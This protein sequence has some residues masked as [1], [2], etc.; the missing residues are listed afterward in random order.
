MAWGD[1]FKSA[2]NKASSGV[3]S[4]AG[5]IA[6]G[7]KKAAG[8]VKDKAVSA[9]NW[10]KNKTKETYNWAKNKAKQGYNWIKDKARKFGKMVKNAYLAV[11]KKFGELKAWATKQICKAKNKLKNCWN[12]ATKADQGKSAGYVKSAVTGKVKGTVT[13]LLDSSYRKE[14]KT[15]LTRKTARGKLAALGNIVDPRQLSPH[16]TSHVKKLFDG[17]KVLGKNF[18][19]ASQRLL[20]QSAKK[21]SQSALKNAAKSFAPKQL[22]LSAIVE[23]GAKV[24]EKGG[25]L[26]K[27]KKKDLIEVAYGVG[28]GATAGAIGAALG[29]FI[30]IPFVGTALGF[31]VGVGVGMAIDHFIKSE[32]IEFLDCIT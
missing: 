13:N 14:L 22:G 30:P 32:T 25:D 29:T 28:T 7:A 11:K 3:R 6:T 20:K 27:I 31:L 9:A 2:W 5:A 17:R 23:F 10:T 19:E 4:A 21:T 24:Y 12:K 26:T 18:K 1:A 15:A 16:P 8:W